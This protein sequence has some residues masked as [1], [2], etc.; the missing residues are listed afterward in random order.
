MAFVE[1]KLRVVPGAINSRNVKVG[2][3]S[4]QEL[5]EVEVKKRSKAEVEKA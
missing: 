5:E 4:N 3:R 1:T 2:T